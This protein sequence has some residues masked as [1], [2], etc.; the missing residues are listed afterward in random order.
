MIT[1][2][3]LRRRSRFLLG[4]TI[5]WNSLEAIVAVASGLSAGSIA[6]VGFGFDSVIEVFA[7][8][9]VLWHLRG[10]SETRERLALRLIGLSFFAL[11]AYITIAAVRDLVV[12]DHPAESLVG[13]ALAVASLVV[14]P[15][16]AIAKRR[17]GQRLGSAT[18]V[19]ESAETFLC[20]YLS[21][22]LLAGLVLNATLGWWWADPVAG[23]VIA[24]LALR[25]GS[26]AWNGS[27]CCDAP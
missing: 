6:L 14:M 17:T 7:A 20:A 11:A 4:A 15:A 3:E 26:E 21:A 16:L 27:A 25:E 18:V 1:A 12:G 2:T 19:A 22:V 10:L 13:I 9:V 23:L 5:A 24:A 8:C